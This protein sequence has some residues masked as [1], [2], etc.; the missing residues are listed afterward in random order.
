PAAVLEDAT[1]CTL[2]VMFETGG[3]RSPMPP[4]FIQAERAVAP[5][6][7]GWASLPLDA[8]SPEAVAVLEREYAPFEHPVVY[9]GP[10]RLRLELPGGSP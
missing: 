2:L 3:L 6:V 10:A 8:I 5:I 7:D 1:A 4:G 9:S